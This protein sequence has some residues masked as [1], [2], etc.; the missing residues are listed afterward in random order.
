LEDPEETMMEQVIALFVTENMDY[1]HSKEGNART[2]ESLLQIADLVG[3][4]DADMTPFRDAEGMQNAKIYCVLRADGVGETYVAVDG[5]SFVKMETYQFYAY[6]NDNDA[7][8]KTGVYVAYDP[9]EGES[10]SAYYSIASA[11]GETVITFSTLSGEGI[12]YVKRVAVVN[13]DGGGLGG[14]GS[15]VATKTEEEKQTQTTTPAASAEPVAALRDVSTSD[16]YYE[17]VKFAVE[18]GLFKGVSESEFAPDAQMTRA[19]LATVLHRLAGE[20]AAAGAAPFGDV[21][22][23][24]W[25]TEAVAWASANGVIDG[26]SAD[27]FGANDA[28]TREQ[29]AVLLYRYAKLMGYDVS[30]TADLSGYA[31][32]GA[33]AE[34]AREAMAW[35]NATGLIAGRGA[36]ALAPADTATRAEVAAMLHRFASATQAAR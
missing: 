12:S 28:V 32:V 6:D 11:G 16:W 17:D 35:A 13:T 33:V 31:D 5:T 19:M 10:E 20:P 14:G 1:D 15:P 8:T 24:R 26:Y 30:A 7:N 2:A 4:W 18:N 34:W 9:S 23:G 22:A 21:P 29:I 27:V 36:N 25:F 3:I